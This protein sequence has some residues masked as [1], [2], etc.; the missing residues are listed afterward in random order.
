MWQAFVITTTNPV[1]T[2]GRCAIA[3]V[4][5]DGLIDIVA[6][7]DRDGLINDQIILLRR[8]SP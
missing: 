8:V 6:P 1:A 5:N 7:L 4:T 2:I 3:D